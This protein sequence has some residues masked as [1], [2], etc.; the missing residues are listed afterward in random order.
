MTYLRQDQSISTVQVI[1]ASTT[2]QQ[3]SSAIKRICNN[4]IKAQKGNWATVQNISV[5]EINAAKKW[6]FSL[7][8]VFEMGLGQQVLVLILF[9]G[10]G[11][12]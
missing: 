5:I 4:F 11:L 8:Q 12:V 1:I 2:G 6:A 3:A 9:L 7:F 10:L